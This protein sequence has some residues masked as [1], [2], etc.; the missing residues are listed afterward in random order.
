MIFL[1]ANWIM[2]FVCAY[3][4]FMGGRFDALHGNR[5]NHGPWWAL[6][7]ILVTVAAIQG[8]EAGWLLVLLSQFLLLVAVT[9]WR[10]VA[11]K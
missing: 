4:Y 3:F 1:Q 7:S 9:I 8:L 6:A 2:G 5:R 11:E 10:V